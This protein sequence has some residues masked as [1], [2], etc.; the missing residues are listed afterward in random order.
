MS[1]MTLRIQHI[2]FCKQCRELLPPKCGKCLSHPE[3]KPRVVA[4]YGAPPI[5][6]TAPCGCVK[7][8]CQRTEC[9]K[10]AWKKLKRTGQLPE[11]NLYCSPLCHVKDVNKLRQS[12]KPMACQEC[13]DMA[14]RPA[15]A[16][17]PGIF[18]CSPAC[19]WINYRKKKHEAGI[20]AKETKAGLDGR[21]LYFC[22]KCND[23]K[24][25]HAIPKSTRLRCLS[26][27][28]TVTA[29]KMDPEKW[30]KTALS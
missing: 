24:E 23:V 29:G 27:A 3:R 8:R 14:R 19:R 26:C 9:G 6:G 15:S 2:R 17:V 21:A 12:S 4:L 5:L 10:D 1:D 18:F 16:L 13:G 28:T 7:V 25:H 22:S 20:A 30:R 11:R